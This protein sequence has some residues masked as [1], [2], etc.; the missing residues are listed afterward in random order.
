MEPKRNFFSLLVVHI[1]FFT[2]LRLQSGLM[3]V[4]PQAGSIFYFILF[5]DGWMDGWKEE[6]ATR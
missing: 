5:L 4:D 2:R 6:E 1:E 3:M